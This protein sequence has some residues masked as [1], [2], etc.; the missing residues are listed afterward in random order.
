[1]DPNNNQIG[2][3]NPNQ[4][5][6]PMGMPQ[7]I[8]AQ[9]EQDEAAF[10]FWGVLNRRKWLVFLGLVTG[11]ALGALVYAKSQTIYESVAHVQIEPKNKPI[12]R[13]G[14]GMDPFVPE[15]N[16]VAHDKLMVK[17]LMVEGMLNKDGGKLRNLK[18]FDEFPKDDIT[19]EVIENLT[20]TPD[21]E[22]NYIYEIR[23]TSTDKEDAPVI[24]NNLLQTYEEQLIAQYQ[25]DQSKFIEEL[26][27][28]EANFQG[29]F[30]AAL[31][32]R[33]AL[34]AEFTSLR[35]AGNTTIHSILVVELGKAISKYRGELALLQNEKAKNDRA[36]AQGPTGIAGRIWEWQQNG[37]VTIKKPEDLRGSEELKISLYAAET[38]A[39]LVRSQVGTGHPDFEEAMVE[40]R[41]LKKRIAEIDA[42]VAKDALSREVLSDEE[43]FNRKNA[44]IAQR[45][46]DLA[47]LIAETD[48]EW[49]LHNN[50]AMRLSAIQDSIAQVDSRIDT[51]RES[52]KMGEGLLV[53]ISPDGD[54]NSAAKNDG[55]RFVRLANALEGESVWPNLP[56]LL[57]LGGLLGSLLGF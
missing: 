55:Y 7:V 28:F 50:E 1:M 41:I 45:I 15:V 9:A 37:E 53:Q 11:L 22:A 12:I 56:L 47:R 57:G 49:N 29:N 30:K 4:M 46:Q 5:G 42:Q 51:I 40:V 33:A 14:R 3:H 27:K 44:E 19:D 8:M 38:R 18:S 43:I 32:E 23:F 13:S 2:Q 52:L 6:A 39:K 34:N 10:D 21:R 31:E 26:R 17:A 54:Y 36:A 25:Q 35:M 24:V 48:E 20:V 16:E